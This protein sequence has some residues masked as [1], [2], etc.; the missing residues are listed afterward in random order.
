[1]RRNFRIELCYELRLTVTFVPTDRSKHTSRSFV[2][3]FLIF[4]FNYE[5]SSD[6][7]WNAAHLWKREAKS[8]ALER[9]PFLI[10]LWFCEWMLSVEG[11]RHDENL[12]IV[13]DKKSY[14]SSRELNSCNQISWTRESDSVLWV[15]FLGIAFVVLSISQKEKKRDFASEINECSSAEQRA[16]VHVHITFSNTHVWRRT[17][18][19]CWVDLNESVAWYPTTMND[20]TPSYCI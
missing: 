11:K 7:I 16:A 13:T 8:S 4:P 6:S 17:P 9:F 15:E 19:A 2:L 18:Y 1:M 14:A 20:I 5:C 12:F 10:W 3:C